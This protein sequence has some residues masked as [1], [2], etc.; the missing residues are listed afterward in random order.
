MISRSVLLNESDWQLTQRLAKNGSADA[1][2]VQEA[3]LAYDVLYRRHREKFSGLLY[4]AI[5][6]QHWVR[7]WKY[8]PRREDIEDLVQDCFVKLYDVAGTFEEDGHFLWWLCQIGKNLWR[9][10]MKKNLTEG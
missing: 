4:W 3:S 7:G 8:R 1:V 2:L 6:T 10:A 9:D 5:E